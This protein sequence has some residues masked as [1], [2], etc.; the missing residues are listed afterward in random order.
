MNL[1]EY[2]KAYPDDD[3]APGWDAIDKS[4]KNIYGEQE[5]M[6][7]APIVSMMIGGEDPIDGISAYQSEVGNPHIHYCTYGFSSLYYDEESVGNDYSRFGF[8]LTFRLKKDGKA[9]QEDA[10]VCRLIQNLA[11]YV[12]E[13]GRWFEENQWIPA[14]GPIY[15]DS[16][17]KLV[18]LAFAI[19]PELPQ[20]E[21]PHGLVDFIQMFGITQDEL[22]KLGKNRELTKN[23]LDEHRLQNPF[24]ITD[25]DRD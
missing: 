4:L 14:N 10:W 19:D 23:L 17:T 8:E 12:F 22:D 16:G 5:P 25:L 2:K 20:I 11:R 1:E 15:L 18:G 9:T 13:T 24:L 7:W 6:H 3:A 21:T